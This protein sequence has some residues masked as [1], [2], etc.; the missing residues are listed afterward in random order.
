MIH[1]KSPTPPH[2]AIQW[3]ENGDHPQDHSIA[4]FDS[5]TGEPFLSEGKIV[6]R[7]RHPEVPEDSVCWLCGF[8]YHAHGWIEPDK[9]KTS[10]VSNVCPGDW[11]IQVGEND[12]VIASQRPGNINGALEDDE[13]VVVEPVVVEQGEP[14]HDDAGSLDGPGFKPA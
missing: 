7:F 6:R 5:E 2:V 4:L 9:R 13:P 10:K 11:I 12:Y 3:H 8:T 1:P 14:A